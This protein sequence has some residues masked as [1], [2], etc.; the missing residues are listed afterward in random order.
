MSVAGLYLNDIGKLAERL[1]GEFGALP[2]D[3]FADDEK[4]VESAVRRLVIME[5]RWAWLWPKVRQ[6]LTP[7]DWRAVTGTWDRKTGR[8]VGIDSKKLWD[9]IVQ[10]LPEISKEARELLK[11]DDLDTWR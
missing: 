8:H 6:R 4:K 11:R 10:K 2:Y 9:T 7:I 5:E 1:I 3:K